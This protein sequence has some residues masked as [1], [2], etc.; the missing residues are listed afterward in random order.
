MWATHRGLS[1][2]CGN[3]TSCPSPAL[4]GCASERCQSFRSGLHLQ[5]QEIAEQDWLL[6]I[7][8]STAK[9]NDSAKMVA[10]RT[11]SLAEVAYVAGCA[12]IDSV[13]HKRGS[14]TQRLSKKLF[15]QVWQGGVAQTE[16][17]LAASI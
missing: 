2:S 15:L 8:A 13:R 16:G 4:G 12:F 9:P 14:L 7:L 3:R 5:V 11:A 6:T 1:K 10:L 17:A